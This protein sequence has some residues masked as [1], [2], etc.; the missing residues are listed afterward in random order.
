MRLLKTLEWYM[1]SYMYYAPC[2]QHGVRHNT[3]FREAQWLE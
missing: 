2:E 3:M 1:V